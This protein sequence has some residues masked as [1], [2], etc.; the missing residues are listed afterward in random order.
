MKRETLIK[1]LE[2]NIMQIEFT[3]VN[4]ELR[5]MHCTLDEMYTP[6]TFSENKKNNDEVLPV[7][8]IDIGAWRSFRLDSVNKIS[9]LEV[10]R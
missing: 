10:T 1:N 8:D 2:K 7:W 9:I 3:K 6:E 4:G 5:V